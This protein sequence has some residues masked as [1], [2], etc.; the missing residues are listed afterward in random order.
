MVTRHKVLRLIGARAAS[1]CLATP[2]DG[3]AFDDANVRRGVMPYELV[4]MRG[5]LPA[6]RSDETREA[7]VGAST[8]KCPSSA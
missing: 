4:T 6:P 3:N 1:S 5:G 2:M 7:L 8:R